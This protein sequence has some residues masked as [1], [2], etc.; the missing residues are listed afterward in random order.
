MASLGPLKGRQKK[1][2]K[3]SSIVKI[4]SLM[5]EVVLQ[6]LPKLEDADSS[7]F[8]IAEEDIKKSEEAAAKE[9]KQSKQE[10]GNGRSSLFK[11][12]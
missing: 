6:I 3:V 8:L 7:G 5:E 12:F 10:H 2:I 11:T 4:K 1:K 9:A